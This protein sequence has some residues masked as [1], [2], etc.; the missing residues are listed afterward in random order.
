MQPTIAERLDEQTEN[1]TATPPETPTE[2]RQSLRRNR[3]SMLRFRHAS[4]PQLSSSYAQADPDA[5]PVPP[6]P[7]R[8]FY[9]PVALPGFPPLRGV[10]PLLTVFSSPNDHHHCTDKS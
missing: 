5:P 1:A 2:R 4:D 3:F 8:K 6:L 9:L 10:T 7:P